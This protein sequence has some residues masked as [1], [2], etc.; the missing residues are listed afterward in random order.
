MGSVLGYVITNNHLVVGNRR[1]YI[2]YI[3]RAG[4]RGGGKPGNCPGPHILGGP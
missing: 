2:T 4:L 1:L 3:P